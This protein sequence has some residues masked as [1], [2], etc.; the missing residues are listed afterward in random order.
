MPSTHSPPSAE[1]NLSSPS[2]NSLGCPPVSKAVV[3]EGR[4]A[5]VAFT[6]Y[7]GNINTAGYTWVKSFSNYTL[8]HKGAGQPTQA[9]LWVIGDIDTLSLGSAH[10]YDAWNITLRLS[11]AATKALNALFRSGPFKSYT[12]QHSILKLKATLKSV[13]EDLRDEEEEEVAALGGDISADDPYPFT[14]DGCALTDGGPV[15]TIRHEISTFNL[16]TC[17]AAEITLLAYQMPDKEP[18]YSIS[19]R[20]IYHLGDT[21]EDVP[22]TPRKRKGGCLISPRRAK[23]GH[24]APDPSKVP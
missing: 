22:T 18:G 10:P 3:A 19:M 2:P 13:R 9:V 24:F 7:I 20:G 17:V 8:C 5:I 12:C 23:H 6:N 1:S 14:Y 11:S 21:P 4:N 16:R 15:P